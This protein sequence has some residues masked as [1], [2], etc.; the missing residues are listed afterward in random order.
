[1]ENINIKSILVCALLSCTGMSVTAQN[2]NH[3]VRTAATP[4]FQ[5]DFTQAAEKTINSVVCI[6][7]YVS[8]V[9]SQYYDPFGGMIDPFEFFFG[10]PQQRQQPKNKKQQKKGEPVQS[11]FCLLYTSPSPRDS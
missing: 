8:R 9:Q 6:K 4:A 2:D 5:T 3:F 11:G 10:T 7:S 1:M